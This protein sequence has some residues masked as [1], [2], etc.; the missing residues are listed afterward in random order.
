[1]LISIHKENLGD[2]LNE[3]ARMWGP[4]GRR[5]LLELI[6]RLELNGDITGNDWKYLKDR[7]ENPK[8]G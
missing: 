1:M 7:L 8:E 6:G 5:L 4:D 2:R 3:T